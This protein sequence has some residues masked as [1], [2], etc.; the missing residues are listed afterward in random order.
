MTRV[1]S[2]FRSKATGSARPRFE[3]QLRTECMHIW[4]N[5]R[6]L[7]DACSLT[8]QPCILR[9]HGSDTPH[10]SGVQSRR[11][12]SCGT[13]DLHM[14][15]CIFPRVIPVSDLCVTRSNSINCRRSFR[16]GGCELQFRLL[17][18]PGLPAA[19]RDG[20]LRPYP[21]ACVV[22]RSGAGPPSPGIFARFEQAFGLARHR[23]N[24]FCTAGGERAGPGHWAVVGHV[25]GRRRS[26]STE[27]A[28]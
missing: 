15:S 27:A 20:L 23:R 13:L 4:Q 11:S 18:V 6:Q 25:R 16:A 1:V 21:R 9:K 28:Q 2:A 7:C 12:C 5:G 26:C 24:N 3:A 14:Y 8:G 19:R 17:P 10:T 22:L